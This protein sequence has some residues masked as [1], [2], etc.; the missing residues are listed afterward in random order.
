MKELDLAE[1][2][3]RPDLQTAEQRR[4]ARPELNAMID[5]RLSTDTQDHWIERLN[6]AGVPCGKVLSVADVFADPQVKA[7]DMVLDV[8][9][10][11]RGMVRMV[12]FPVKLSETP[13]QLRHPSPELGAH[14]GEVLVEAGYSA[15]EIAGLRARKCIGGP[16][17]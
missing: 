7:Q 8:D 10:G 12:G 9:Q 4:A 2:L 13:A 6:A 5:R 3:D 17:A 1:V 14:T 16:G 15:E 11:R